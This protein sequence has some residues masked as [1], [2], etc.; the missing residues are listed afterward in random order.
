MQSE[1]CP[2]CQTSAPRR[3]LAGGHDE[4]TCEL[5]GCFRIDDRL[6]RAPTTLDGQLWPNLLGAV[7]ELQL[8]HP[9][10]PHIYFDGTVKTPDGDG[11]THAAVTNF[12]VTVREHAYRLLSNLIAKTKRFGDRLTVHGGRDHP[13]AYARDSGEFNAYL[14]FLIEQGFVM[15]HHV[16]GAGYCVSVTASGFDNSKSNRELLP[17][18]VFISSTCYDLKDCRAEIGHHLESCGSIVLLSDD[19][20]RFDVTPT[21]DSIQSCLANVR[22]SDVVIC[23]IDQRYGGALPDET[24]GQK[25]ATHVEIDY[26]KKID[27]PIYFFIRKEAF[28]EWSMLKKD[29]SRKSTWVE[30]N[31]K[32]QRKRWVEFV[33]ENI[34]LPHDQNTS[35]WFDQFETAVDLKLMIEKRLNA[36]RQGV[37]T[38]T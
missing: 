12:P 7:R 26:A 24:Y 22:S 38:A 10:T 37:T 3:S 21:S 8:R 30:P 15:C 2:L 35:N 11:G 34:R 33:S 31:K 14:D 27:K 36:H 32:E 13:L 29:P 5:C 25:S 16:T 28:T 20:L 18:T 17:L 9:E 4:F 6:V 19:P 23:L 1:T